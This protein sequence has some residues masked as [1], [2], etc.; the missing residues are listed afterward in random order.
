MIKIYIDA[1]SAI[2]D[3]EV[4]ATSNATFSSSTTRVLSSCCEF[5][6]SNASVNFLILLSA[7]TKAASCPRMRSWSWRYRPPLLA[8]PPKLFKKRTGQCAHLAH[9]STQYKQQNIIHRN[10]LTMSK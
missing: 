2:F 8:T 5:A 4:V 3:F 7:A 6:R 1:Y 9:P 10:I